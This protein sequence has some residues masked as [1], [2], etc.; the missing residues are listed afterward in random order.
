MKL[1]FLFIQ[2]IPFSLSI[3]FKEVD[4]VSL[5]FLLSLLP[6]M[7]RTY[8]TA[9]GEKVITLR[10]CFLSEYSLTWQKE[11]YIVSKYFKKL[12]LI[13][14]LTEFIVNKKTFKTILVLHGS[15]KPFSLFIFCF[16]FSFPHCS[17]VIL[18]N[19]VLITAV[20]GRT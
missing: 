8:F 5:Q 10:E 7:E 3:F 16:P 9:V 1:V 15:R 2:N 6:F 13:S 4:K 12:P 14:M 20:I 19:Y 18:K 17:L 11:Q